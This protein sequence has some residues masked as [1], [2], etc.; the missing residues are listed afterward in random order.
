[1]AG[2]VVTALTSP[3]A[4]RVF[5]RF[6]RGP[7]RYRL[8]WAS[9]GRRRAQNFRVAAAVSAN[10]PELSN[11]PIDAPWEVVVTERSG[12]GGSR[13]FTELWPVG[14][15]DP[16]FTYRRHA[17]F[18]SSHPTLAAALARASGV[19]R[20]DVVWDPFAGSAT[21]LVE[22]ARLGPY[23]RLYGTDLESTALER[24]HD[25]LTAAAVERWELAAGDA[26]TFRLPVAPSL[27]IT[28]PPYGKRVRTPVPIAAVLEAT[29]GNVA[30][31]LAPG[32]RIVWVTPEPVATGRAATRSGLTVTS[33]R[34]ID[35][36]GIRAELQVLEPAIGRG[37]PGR[38]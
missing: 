2:A 33:R 32:G 29:L 38:G 21:E 8:S 20:D 37:R 26:R 24:A 17:L 5:T 31:Q 30:S 35:V 34:P 14:L 22:R 3:L 4:V 10:R 12:K 23:A 7:I 19:R 18:A 6:T 27:I 25:N 11:D 15:A 28:N 1:V 13:I 36:G 9:G 16:R